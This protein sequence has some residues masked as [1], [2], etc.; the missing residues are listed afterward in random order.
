[1]GF[2]KNKSPPSLAHVHTMPETRFYS[3]SP[4]SIHKPCLCSEASLNKAASDSRHIPP[5]PVALTWYME[6]EVRKEEEKYYNQLP[7]LYQVY[8]MEPSVDPQK[9][10]SSQC[11]G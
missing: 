10:A 4:V 1:M 7:T 3:T 5:L 2:K 8:A 11:E 6:M 9:V